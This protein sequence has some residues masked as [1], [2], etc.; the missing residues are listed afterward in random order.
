MKSRKAVTEALRKELNFTVEPPLRDD[1]LARALQELQQSCETQPALP[2]PT[3][4]R[5]IMRISTTKIALAALIGAGVVTAAAVGVKYHFI[6]TDPER[7][8]LVRSEDGHSGMNIPEKYASGPEQA[9]ETAEEIARLKQL[10]QRELVGV[11]EIDVNGQLDGRV[12]SYKYILADGR[13]ITVGERDPDDNALWTLVGE[14]QEEASRL[15]R[16]AVTSGQFVTTDQGTYRL[17]ADG[18]EIPTFERVFQGR[19]F[20]FHKYT[21]TLSDGTEVTRSIGRLCEDSPGG[22]TPDAAA[23]G[24]LTLKD[25]QEIIALRQQDRRQVVGVRELIANGALDLRTFVYRYQLPDGRTIEMN[26]DAGSKFLL[27]ADQRKEWLQARKA[28]AGQDLDGY[29]EQVLGRTYTFTRQRFVLSDGTELIWSRGT[30]KDN[31]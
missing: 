15:F 10:G 26:E 24:G 23:T 19:T 31:Q 14:R 25:H 22:K 21:V 5:M 9:V 12:L 3:T 2:E 20:T 16:E 4:R 27:N 29:E 18:K 8:Y 11:S 30:P 13:T 1:L 6:G 7:G 17:T 28:G